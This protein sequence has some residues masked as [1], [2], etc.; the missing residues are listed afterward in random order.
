MFYSF[1]KSISRKIPYFSPIEKFPSLVYCPGMR[2][3][4]DISF[5][6]HCIICLVVAYGRLK[7]KKEIKLLAVKVVAGAYKRFQI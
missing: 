2:Y 7:T 6:L 3:G 1:E 4:F 5:N